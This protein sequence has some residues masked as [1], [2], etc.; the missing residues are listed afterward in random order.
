MKKLPLTLAFGL[1]ALL[2]RADT[3]ESNKTY[4]TGSPIMVYDSNR[5]LTSGSVIVP[6]GADVRYVADV[7]VTLNAGFKVNLGGV[8]LAVVG[9]DSDGDGMPNPWEI[10]Y[11]FD[12]A[13]NDAGGDAD[14]DGA[15]N[16]QE[17]LLGTNP[18]TSN[19]DSGN[20]TQLNI[21]RPPQ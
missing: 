14:S 21:H 15:T 5:V 2:A 7:G 12:I 9:T 19:T 6:N 17:Y 16:L 11:G 10:T 18:V 3:T 4:S 8:F 13:V 20:A 1:S